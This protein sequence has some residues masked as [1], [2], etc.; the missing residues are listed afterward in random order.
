MVNELVH[1]LGLRYVAAAREDGAV[2]MA[3]AY[4]RA[5]GQ[6]G[7]ATVTYG[8]GLTN[9]LTALAEAA[10]AR[11]PM[12]ILTGHAP[13]ASVPTLWQNLQTIDHESVVRPT[14]AIY[15]RIRALETAIDDILDAVRLAF[16]R[17]LPVVLGVPTDLQELE[18]AFELPRSVLPTTELSAASVE[19]LDQAAGIL[20]SAKRCVILAG[21]GAVRSGAR[22][23]LV[24]LSRRLQA[25]LATTL[26]ARDLFAGEPYAIDIC[27]SLATPHATEVI[28]KAD[29]VLAIGAS[30]NRLTTFDRELLKG[31]VVV[32][33]DADAEAIGLHH[34][35]ECGVVGDASTTVDAFNSM[36]EEAGLGSDRGHEDRLPAWATNVL[37]FDA[38]EPDA[39]EDAP[40]R[41]VIRRLDRMLPPDRGVVVDS[42]R[43]CVS[44]LRHMRAPDPRSFTVPLSFL[45]VG[46]GLSSAVGA[47]FARPE[48]PTVL[49]VGDG[50]MMMSLTDLYTAVLHRLDLVV[51]VINND[52]YGQEIVRYERAGMNPELA[53]Q[54]APDFAE[55][56]Q[57]FGARGA[58]V[59]SFEELE[60]CLALVTPGAGPLVI[61]VKVNQ[62]GGSLAQQ[63]QPD[64]AIAARAASNA[65]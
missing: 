28:A 17:R 25:P 32:H 20:A 29:C 4:A 43:F 26:L 24:E 62:L 22:D 12:I 2:L 48:R 56:A 5:T 38:D 3:N 14:G 63:E 27:G 6:L 33:C 65:L 35:V 47:A 30:L 55:V 18:F 16:V 40:V 53:C 49:V 13:A 9:A 57:S 45:V 19:A 34:G 54:I 46:F 36:L 59:R 10:R 39:D 21:Y 23:G 15:C 11:T 31:K 42:G 64:Q 7:L 52:A 60:D 61:D 50:G 51:V 44:A 1:E 58:T 8:P 41:E 37:Q